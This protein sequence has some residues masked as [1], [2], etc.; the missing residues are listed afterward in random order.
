[1]PLSGRGGAHAPLDRKQS[2]PP[3]RSAPAPGYAAVPTGTAPHSGQR[4]GVARR[5]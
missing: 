1:M 4:S 2:I 3:P 5:S